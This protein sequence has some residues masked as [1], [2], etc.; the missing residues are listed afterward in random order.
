[1]E[2]GLQPQLSDELF[3]QMRPPRDFPSPSR[4]SLGRDDECV[5]VKPVSAPVPA[6]TKGAVRE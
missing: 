5:P 4:R 3:E 1:M 6:E 2:D